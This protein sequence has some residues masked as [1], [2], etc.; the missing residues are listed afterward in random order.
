MDSYTLCCLV[1]SNMEMLALQNSD[2]ISCWQL[3][4]SSYYGPE[5][6]LP[7]CLDKPEIMQLLFRY[8]KANCCG[9]TLS[10][11]LEMAM[12]K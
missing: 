12:K 10:C 6:Q 7:Q 5:V 11:A 4:S 8:V 1:S 9:K 2:N 3:F